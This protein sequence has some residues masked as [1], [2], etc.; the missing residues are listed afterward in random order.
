VAAM[1]AAIA[2]VLFIVKFCFNYF[3]SNSAGLNSKFKSSGKFHGA[4]Y[5]SAHFKLDQICI[6]EKDLEISEVYLKQ[7]QY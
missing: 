3:I 1:R 6:F 2:K 7:L 4:A 5:A